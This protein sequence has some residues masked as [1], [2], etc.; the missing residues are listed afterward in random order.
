MLP[1]LSAGS[2]NENSDCLNQSLC[3]CCPRW[4]QNLANPRPAERTHTAEES[5]TISGGTLQG[6][7]PLHSPLEPL[8]PELPRTVPTSMRKW[9]G[10]VSKWGR[11]ENLHYFQDACGCKSQAFQLSDGIH[12]ALRAW[13]SLEFSEGE[14]DLQMVGVLHEWELQRPR[15]RPWVSGVI[16]KLTF[17]LE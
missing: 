1:R 14:V 6:G 2:Q 15:G 5:H 4:S 12:E 17:I 9:C 13:A 7:Q 10:S 8:S 3:L 16:F 11:R